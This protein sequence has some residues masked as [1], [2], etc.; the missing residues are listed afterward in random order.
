MTEGDGELLL[1]LSERGPQS[2]TAWNELYFRHVRYLFAVCTKAFFGLLRPE[3]IEELVQDTFIRAYDKASTFSFDLAVDKVGQQK[4]VRAWLGALSDSIARD[5]FRDQPMVDFV[6]DETLESFADQSGSDNSGSTS[7]TQEVLEAA[8]AT[9]NEREQQVLRATAFWFKPEATNQRLP[10]KVM[11]DLAADLQTSPSN[12]R[13]IRKR[14]LAKFR[15]FI[16]TQ[17]IMFEDEK[18]A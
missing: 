8:M 14:A 1:L 11:K 6:D 2:Q 9:L 3:Q 16:Q 18:D 15:E 10:N 17:G 4:A 5:Y 7:E 13:Q 12:I